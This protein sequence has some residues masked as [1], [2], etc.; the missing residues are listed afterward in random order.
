MSRIARLLDKISQKVPARCI[1]ESI[2]LCGNKTEL[3]AIHREPKTVFNGPAHF[4]KTIYD[5]S[6]RKLYVSREMPQLI[7]VLW[8]EYEDVAGLSSKKIRM[9]A[10]LSML[11]KGEQ[12]ITYGQILDAVATRLPAGRQIL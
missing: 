2:D 8:D 9:A 4:V 6:F 5:P 3:I 7:G 1:V 10:S 11:A 12:A